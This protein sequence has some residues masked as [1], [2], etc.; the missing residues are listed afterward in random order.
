MSGNNVTSGGQEPMNIDTNE[1]S[2]PTPSLSLETE[3]ARPTRSTLYLPPG[4]FALVSVRPITSQQSQASEIPTVPAAL[5]SRLQRIDRV[6]GMF[7]SSIW[8]RSDTQNLSYN[9]LPQALRILATKL[10]RTGGE[11]RL[12]TRYIG[13]EL[14][15][16]DGWILQM[17]AASEMLRMAFEQ[18]TERLDDQDAHHQATSS[19]LHQTIQAEG[20]AAMARDEEIGR[21]LLDQRNQHQGV[22]REHGQ[23]FR[24]AIQE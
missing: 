9:A 15:R 19:Q 22:L 2:R 12:G 17:E 6:L 16:I 23:A 24:E 1:I 5:N 13:T 14:S 21:E 7:D 18:V 8:H 4:T 20:N 3:I 10:D 11:I